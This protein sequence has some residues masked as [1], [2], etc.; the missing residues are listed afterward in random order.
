MIEVIY[1]TIEKVFAHLAGRPGMSG[2]RVNSLVVAE[3]VYVAKMTSLSCVMVEY[4][5]STSMKS[6]QVQTDWSFMEERIWSLTR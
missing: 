1:K 4:Q 2:V 6:V 5:Q 3:V